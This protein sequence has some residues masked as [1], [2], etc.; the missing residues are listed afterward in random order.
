M[1]KTAWL[2]VGD[3]FRKVELV[4]QVGGFRKVRPLT[5]KDAGQ[6]LVLP[7]DG[8]PHGGFHPALFVQDDE[9]KVWRHKGRS[10][11]LVDRSRFPN[12]AAAEA[13]HRTNPML[14]E[15]GKPVPY[16]LQPHALQVIDGII[17]GDHQL[18]I[19]HKGC[20]K[21]SVVLFIA[22]SVGQPVVRVNFTGQVSI[23]DLVGSVGFGPKGTTWHDGPVI[24][25]MRTGAW[26]LCDEF[27][28]CDASV[29]SLFHSICEKQPSYC[30]K[31]NDG[32]VVIAQPSFRFFATG[33]SIA[34][35]NDGE[36]AGTQRLNAALL[37][38][39]AGHGRIIEVK[40]MT[41][42]Q[43]RHM[44]AKV[45]PELPDRL[46]QKAANFAAKVRSEHLKSFSTR[47]LVN[48]VQ[49]MV[50]YKDPVVAARMTFLPLV[51]NPEVRSGIEA[52]IQAIF[53]NRIVVGRC[54]ATNGGGEQ[55]AVGVADG[56]H[57]K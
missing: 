9:P 37:D 48:F 35:D 45:L 51:E 5:G 23:S 11:P 49:K 38:R 7:P 16:S 32:E 3:G 2:P 18:L 52:G 29:A 42:K 1:T 27:D 39:F 24:A 36:Y 57:R 31:E 10:L 56:R 17:A 28:M 13:L 4:G 33:N 26:L 54:L 40:A 15:T 12:P 47:E 30:L 25:A 20:G 34:G 6:E 21:T 8:V 14:D 41:A 55:S 53:G 44:L 46:A 19:G 22:A 43:E 50:Q